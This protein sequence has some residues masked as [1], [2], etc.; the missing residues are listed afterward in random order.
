MGG[1]VFSHLISWNTSEI[2]NHMTSPYISLSRID[3]D[4]SSHTSPIN[5]MKL[6]I[7]A[8]ILISMDA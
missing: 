5:K 8:L 1:R 4:R 2:L 7:V 3:N 6:I